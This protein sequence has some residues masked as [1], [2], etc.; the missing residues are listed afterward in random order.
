MATQNEEIA[1]GLK[2]QNQESVAS[3]RQTIKDLQNEVLNLAE[4]TELWNKKM[5]ELGEAKAR[6]SDL[7]ET[8]SALDPDKK[9]AAWGNL[10]NTIVGGF[11]GAAGAA[12]LFGVSNEDLEKTFIKLQAAVGLLQSLQTIADAKEQIGHLKAIL[13]WKS[14]AAVI[15]EATVATEAQAGAT[16]T[17]TVA[18]EAA[19]VAT[20]SWTA[21]LLANPIFAIAAVLA[22][23]AAAIIY[24]ASREK[25]EIKVLIDS[26]DARQKVIDKIKEQLDRQKTVQQMQLDYADAVGQT[27]QEIDQMRIAQ[28]KAN[29]AMLKGAIIEAQRQLKNYQGALKK[30]GDEGA[31][32]WTMLKVGVLNYL[33]LTSTAADEL[34]GDITK[35]T[36]PIQKKIDD[37]AKQIQAFRDEIEKSST[38]ILKNQKDINEADKADYEKLLQKKQNAIIA[39]YDILIAQAK[40]R[41]EDTYGLEKKSLEEQISVYK[42]GTDARKKLEHDYVI[43]KQQAHVDQL[44][45]QKHQQE[46]EEQEYQEHLNKM[47]EADV[48]YTAKKKEGLQDWLAKHKAT[49]DQAV[50]LEQQLSGAIGDILA[51]RQNNELAAAKG[52]AVQQEQIRKKYFEQNKKLQ[53][54]QTVIN[55]L[56]ALVKT[57][58]EVPFPANIA[59]AA[60]QIAATGAA[61]AKI[62]STQYEGGG[63]T[64]SISTA[65]SA[66]S[67]PAPRL[68]SPTETRIQQ[69]AVAEQN[70]RSGM[71][72]LRNSI[73]Q[74]Q[75]GTVKAFV[76]ESERQATAERL[77][78][79]QKRRVF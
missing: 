20:K 42:E 37:A 79:M 12:L 51:A 54:A 74:D 35:T 3:L 70:S 43:F 7:K 58:A 77:D 36:D 63:S 23:A 9:A 31:S 45:A 78:Q 32:T 60:V 13:G 38:N 29:I 47:A 67:A 8:M 17:S 19:D 65:A 66:A 11:Q 34:V 53:I 30:V 62:K 24:F 1:I 75:R 59:V 55:G 64:S 72:D 73:A 68:F 69:Q 40:A 21:S 15:T 22:A 5:Q 50:Q 14:R 56:A 76:V 25:D 46:Q 26:G 41:G 28:D 39:Y 18:T 48:Q 27:R 6:M 44:D 2:V 33:G 52:N 57:A 10:A 61:I 16:I 4:G 49:I 71:E